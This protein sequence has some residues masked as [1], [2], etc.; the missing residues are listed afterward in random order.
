[1]NNFAEFINNNVAFT[2]KRFFDL[3]MLINE[4][5]GDVYKDLGIKFPV[6][7]SSTVL[8]LAK[9]QEGSLTEI[10]AGLGISHQLVSQRVKILLNLELITKR[11]TPNDKRKTI[12]TFTEEGDQQSK[13]LLDYCSS[14][15]K[16]FNSLSETVGIDLLATINK[17]IAALN[18]TSFAERYYGHG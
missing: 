2:N 12:Y 11:P 3:F 16:A 8:Y 6:V 4:Q 17:A 13:L 7:A 15:E 9:S 1:M 14:A 18:E 10:A 5:A